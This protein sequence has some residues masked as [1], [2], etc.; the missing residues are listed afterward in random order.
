MNGVRKYS[1]SILAGIAFSVLILGLGSS[2]NAYAG[3]GEF[4]CEEEDDFCH[5]WSGGIDV[6]TQNGVD[7]WT[8]PNNWFFGNVPDDP[9]DFVFIGCDNVDGIPVRVGGFGAPPTN[10]NADLD[11]DFTF[12][13]DNN[14]DIGFLFL[15]D[16]S[17]LNVLPGSSLIF[18]SEQPSSAI[19]VFWALIGG[20]LNIQPNGEV[21][22]RNLNDND[23][24][25][26]V[27]MANDGTINNE[28]SFRV[29]NAGTVDTTVGIPG[30]VGI[31]SSPNEELSFLHDRTTHQHEDGDVGVQ[32]NTLLQI[33][34]TF[35]NGGTIDND[36]F[37][38]VA[39]TADVT[40]NFNRGILSHIHLHNDVAGASIDNSDTMEI[41]NNGDLS[42]DGGFGVQLDIEMDLQEN[43]QFVTNTGDITLAND[44]DITGTNDAV[45]NV[46][47]HFDIDKTDGV[48]TENGGDSFVLINT[49][50]LS[51]DGEPKCCDEKDDEEVDSIELFVQIDNQG[52][53]NVLENGFLTLENNGDL[54]GTSLTDPEIEMDIQFNDNDGRLEIKEGGE[55][56]IFNSGDG[57]ANPA[58]GA[59]G[60]VDFDIEFDKN[61]GFIFNAGTLEIEN[62][63]DAIAWCDVD[64]DVFFDPNDG[65]IRN[66]GFLKLENTGDATVLTDCAFGE[67]AEIEVEI[68][69]DGD[70]GQGNINNQGELVIFNSGD[71]DRIE[72]EIENG[73]D[74]PTGLVVN[75]GTFTIENLGNAARSLTVGI[76]NE[77]ATD[78]INNECGA[79]FE[80]INTDT[81]IPVSE[82]VGIDNDGIINNFKTGTFSVT[83]GAVTTKNEAIV[84]DGNPIS[85][86]PSCLNISSC[87]LFASAGIGFP[88][89]NPPE[90]QGALGLVGVPLDG[91]EMIGN[92]TDSFADGTGMPGLAFDNNVILYG[93]LANGALPGNLIIID[94]ETGALIE[95]LGVF[96]LDPGE[97]ESLHQ[98][99]DLTT[100]PTNQLYGMKRDPPNGELF[101]VFPALAAGGVVPVVSAGNVNDFVGGDDLTVRGL[102][103][104]LDGRLIATV[105]APTNQLI[106]IKLNDDGDIVDVV[107]L[108]DNENPYNGLG[109]CPSG[110]L[111]ATHI[112]NSHE[113]YLLDPDSGDEV[114]IGLGEFDLSDLDFP[115]FASTGSSGS[116]GHEPP[117]IGKSL[118]GVRQVVDGGISIDAQTW[119][120]TQGYHQEFELLQMLSSPHTISNVIHCAKGV[121]YCN[122]IAVGF[123]GLTDDFNNPVMTVS[124]SKDHLGSWTLNWFD[125]DDFISDPDDAVAGDIVFVPQIIDNN[126]LGTS[127][128]ID[129]KNKDTGQLKMG[130]QVRD[131]YN[132]VRNFYFNEGVE[133][134][135]A[136]AY[137]AAESAYDNPIEVEPLCFGQNNPDRNSCQFA[138]IKDWATANAE[139]TLNQMMGNQYE[140]KQ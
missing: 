35:L 38:Q 130:I 114:I 5:V 30:G 138:K 2:Q 16:G 12:F 27:S 140:Y 20:T 110:A 9:L 86:V 121:Q 85:F 77:S 90:V 123:M 54:T 102:A 64:I 81:I 65:T 41:E 92:P 4:F 28:G 55:V 103:F 71:A 117:T 125:P 88:G 37:F 109:T 80:I 136:D 76:I 17:T 15:C 62:H 139:E 60:D 22:V 49:G 111:F 107:I 23:D 69:N 108:H 94:R 48:M 59:A 96:T 133:F 106:E 126:L 52:T 47:I 25:V 63:G 50:A 134:I 40:S 10:V 46:E 78:I 24:D 45:V 89:N 104:L 82:F 95:D 120:V 83:D 14:S 75:A 101:K 1:F 19:D 131:S 68:H 33:D 11:T 97:G 56:G 127:F 53:I 66:D 3:I 57:F 67:E 26:F 13:T 129:F 119:T 44:H 98:I 113:L 91:F 84:V 29:Y 137:P 6:G 51:S 7:N 39:N 124:A 135:D 79:L 112:E 74:D 36:G 72:V 73:E 118:D 132:G 128:T 32:T 99:A 100:S 31:T 70:E 122:Y 18:E 58:G 61:A 116:T 42:Q 34:I 93:A 105:T 43:D 8:D 115:I 87:E 21:E